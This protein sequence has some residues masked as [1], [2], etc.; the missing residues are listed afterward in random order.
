MLTLIGELL[1]ETL[2]LDGRTIRTLRT[3]IHPGRLTELYVNGKRAPYLTPP[4]LYLLASLILFSSAFTLEPLDANTVDFYLGG[5]LLTTQEP[6]GGRPDLTFMNRN[7]MFDRWMLT[8]YAENFAR[9][10]AMPAQ[11]AIN[12]VFRG[13]RNAMPI[14]LIAFLPLLALA[15]KLLYVRRHVLYVDHLVFA[16]HFQSALFFTFAAV[17]VFARILQVALAWTLLLQVIAFFLMVTIY[18]ST[19]L[20]RLY[21]ESRLMTAGKTFALFFAYMYSLQWVVGPAM[22]FVFAQV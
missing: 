15:L 16:A 1:A 11:E 18:L 3:L 22:I 4:R 9:V 17:W 6:V 10:Q 20:R 21:G 13:L 7:S 2:S 19:A 5:K 14:A 12:V 8:H